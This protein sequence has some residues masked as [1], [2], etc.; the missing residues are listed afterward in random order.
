MSASNAPRIEP[1]ADAAPPAAF[2]SLA[3]PLT[4][5]GIGAAEKALAR[6]LWQ[7]IEPHADDIIDSFYARVADAQITAHVTSRAVGRL[8]VRQKEHWAALFGSEFNDTYA[9]SVRRIGIRHRDIALDPLWHVAGYMMM[10]IE[11]V[12][13]VVAAP[14]TPHEKGHLI[15]TLD[16]YVA[17]DMGLALST[18]NASIVD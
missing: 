8:K 17:I 6:L 3:K 7:L 14:L 10:K 12:K 13:V 18:Y 16:K 11:M 2:M 1:E 5:L 9:N 15:K 4:F